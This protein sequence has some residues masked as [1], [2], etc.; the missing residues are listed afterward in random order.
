[1][2][3]SKYTLSLYEEFQKNFPQGWIDT[4]D[5]TA[6]TGRIK[7]AK[8]GIA[9]ILDF[10][11]KMFSQ[12]ARLVLS[13]DHL[14]N[15]TE[16]LKDLLD[17]TFEDVV[18]DQT[19]TSKRKLQLKY[20]DLLNDIHDSIYL[21]RYHDKLTRKRFEQIERN[22]FIRAIPY[23]IQ[24]ENRNELVL[25][26]ESICDV[27]WIEYEFSYDEGYIRSLL[28]LREKLKSQKRGKTPEHIMYIDASIEK[29]D[30]L[31]CKL[32][33][34]AK[35]KQIIYDYDFS[36]ITISLANSTQFKDDDFRA[37]F[38]DF[39][40]VER[41]PSDKIR[42]WEL[43]K[44][45][46]KKSVKLWKLV[47]LMRYYTKKN[48][49]KKKIDDLVKINDRHFK[50][51]E[52]ENENIVN[53]LAGR[54]GRNYMYN[55]RF[56]SKCKDF[57][58]YTFK[59][60]K[61]DLNEI[62]NIQEETFIHNYHPYQKAI[63]YIINNIKSGLDSLKDNYVALSEQFVFLENCFVKFKDNV[64]WCKK[65]QPY[66]LHLRYN[67]STIHIKGN[68]EDNPIDVFY[69]SSF[70]RPLRFA[71]LDKQI[72]DF[73]HEI[74]FLKY[75]INHYAERL[76]LLNAK[77]KINTFERKN[78]EYIGLTTS[79][80]AFL[81]GLL[82]IFIGNDGNVS[83]FTKMEYVTALGLILLLFVC[84]GYF[85]VSDIKEKWKPFIFGFIS[86]LAFSYI[87]YF[88][89]DFHKMKYS[90]PPKA[91]IKVTA[92]SDSTTTTTIKDSMNVLK[93]PKP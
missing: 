4:L 16:K 82:S 58:S 71:H 88:F 77:K 59:E 44:D 87:G 23:D 76:E 24:R 13:G 65:N 60:M 93:M 50:E 34:F 27:C 3:E 38:V 54:S 73:S 22:E 28:M 70:C 63:E 32:S 74:A 33:I 14:I 66:F 37:Y 19:N 41:I 17:L 8:T 56:S 51:S 40:D 72:L 1:M 45:P 10:E 12:L 52:A 18:T 78:L 80:M 57:K 68:R 29:L 55:S 53:K 6:R 7:K 42:E 49:S 15:E 31:L 30:V 11:K 61:K 2:S 75:E 25:L 5:W 89:L 91:E 9:L 86:A 69:P 47:F 79:A 92:N 35:D 26:L 83:I 81:V 39:M 90:S 46:K 64:D 36:E 84:V 21:V 20:Q 67:F 85:M 48:K 62:E 43:E